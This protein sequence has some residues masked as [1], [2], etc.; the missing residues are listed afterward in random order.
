MAN[1]AA[2]EL[3]GD[4]SI[5]PRTNLKDISSALYKRFNDWKINKVQ[6]HQP[7]QQTQGLPDLQPGFSRIEKDDH[8]DPG[9]GRTLIF[10]EDATR[11]AQ[12]FQQVKLASLGRLT[13]SIAHEIRNPLAAINHASQLLGETATDKADKKLTGIINAQAKRLNNI[14]ENVLQLSRQQQGRQEKILLQDWLIKFRDEFISSH[15]LQENQIQIRLIPDDITILFD[16]TQL[17]QVMWNLFT[18]VINHTGMSKSDIRINIQGNIDSKFKQPC[19]NIID[20][21]PGINK[22]SRAHIFEP[23][24]T[25][26]SSGTGLGLYITREVIESN[27]AKIRYIEQEKGGTCF[28]IYFQQPH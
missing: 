15:G 24:F 20:N 23:F 26:S 27:R 3:L 17:H 22:E 8:A 25:T 2:L 14:I 9:Q 13:A 18:N 11:I 19:I 16:S 4:V 6:N 28:R 21:G 10:V 1:T 7:I 12:R 5:T